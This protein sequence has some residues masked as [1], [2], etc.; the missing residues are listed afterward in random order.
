MPR[1]VKV[2]LVG[3]LPPPF[4]GIPRYVQDLYKANIDGVTFA[5]FN[6]AFPSWIAPYNREGK[7]SYASIVESGVW[8][9]LKKLCYV[10][11]SYSILIGR[12]LSENPDIVQVFTCSYWGYWRNWL[13]VLTAKFCGKKTIF[14]LLNAIDLFYEQAGKLGKFWIRKSLNTA[15]I[16]LLQS[17][18]L[19]RWVDTY[20]QKQSYGLWN[21]ID[22]GEIPTGNPAPTDQC[23]P[24][25]PEG[26]TLGGLGKNKG[27]YDIIDVLGELRTEGIKV[28]WI[29]V[30]NGNIEAFRTLAADQGVSDAILFTGMVS[31]A[32]KWAC[33][34]SAEFYCLPSY[35]EG[36]PMSI[37]EAMAVGLPVIATSVGSIPEMIEHETSG[38]LIQPGDRQS[39]AL[40]IKK[41]VSDLKMREKMGKNAQSIARERHNITDL[42]CGLKRIYLEMV[43]A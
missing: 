8:G 10:L 25:K 26:V 36:Q 28:N 42:F 11:A 4:G 1:L 5:I 34:R 35:A 37:I 16:Y 14:H 7:M 6:T 9:V 23:D 32:K 43:D 22:F 3:P 24:V 39:L 18:G 33:L 38:L 41:M 31:E 12:L 21:G 13:Y 15:D 19:K 29:F 2:L 27:T 20:C 17:P 40:A 30:G